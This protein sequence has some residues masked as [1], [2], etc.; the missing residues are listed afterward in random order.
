MFGSVK[1][2]RKYQFFNL[3]NIELNFVGGNKLTIKKESIFSQ[4]WKVI[5]LE[6]L[7]GIYKTNFSIFPWLEKY[8]ITESKN[9]SS[10]ENLL[11][12][13]IFYMFSLEN[14]SSGG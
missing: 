7:I 4:T 1:I 5:Y 10:N 6:Q 2:T 9:S 13:V 11:L 3:K 12:F 14:N 8:S